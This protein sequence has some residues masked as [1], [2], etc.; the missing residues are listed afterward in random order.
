MSQC[1]FVGGVGAPMLIA[2]ACRPG[3]V[4]PLEVASLKVA[5]A[6]VAAVPLADPFVALKVLL[7]SLAFIISFHHFYLR[8]LLYPFPSLHL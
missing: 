5:V 8:F 2:G 1:R 4:P 3:G 6:R 7:T